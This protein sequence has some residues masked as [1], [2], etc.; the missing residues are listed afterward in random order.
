MAKD[1]KW[2]QKAIKRPGAFSAKAK[3]RGMTTKQLVRAVKRNPKKY[4]STTVKQANLA[5]TLM[6][7]H[8]G[9]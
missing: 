1:K 3:N 2:I 4:D 8:K 6:N 9:G 5:S 7:M